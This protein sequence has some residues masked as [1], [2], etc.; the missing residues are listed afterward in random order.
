VFRLTVTDR[1]GI[2]AS[3]FV[4]VI[5]KP[6]SSAGRSANESATN[7]SEDGSGSDESEL[8]TQNDASQFILED[9][10]IDRMEDGTATI[11]NE[12]GRRIYEGKWSSEVYS[13]VFN[14]RGLYLYQVVKDGKRKTGKVYITDTQ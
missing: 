6:S 13:Q 10:P 1:S 11:Y 7:T 4:T 14:Q 8:S 9:V 12:S 2:Q 5:V 3:D